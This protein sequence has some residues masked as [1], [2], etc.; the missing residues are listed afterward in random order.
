MT[1]NAGKGSRPRNCFSKS[2]RDNYELIFNTQKPLTKSKVTV[3][4]KA[5]SK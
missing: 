2:F 4:P 5:K 1:N 3:K